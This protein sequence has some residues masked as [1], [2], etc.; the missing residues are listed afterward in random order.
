MFCD[1]C[2]SALPGFYN[3]RVCVFGFGR[4]NVSLI[5]QRTTSRLFVCFFDVSRVEPLF[6]LLVSAAGGSGFEMMEFSV[7]FSPS[8]QIV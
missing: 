6:F 2:R 1:V 8:V 3:T 7:L 4:K 5:V